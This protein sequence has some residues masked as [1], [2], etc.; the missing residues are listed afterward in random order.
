M[1]TGFFF[2]EYCFWHTTG[3]H[4]LMLPVGG[5]VQGGDGGSHAEAPSTKRRM[6]SLMDVSGLTA[7]LDLQS[8]PAATVDDLLRV[9]TKGYVDKFMATSKAGGGYIGID[10]P[11]G[12]GTFEV[13]LQSAGLGIGAVDAVLSGRH[14]N[15]YALTRPPGHHCQRDEGMGFCFLA[16]SSIVIEWAKQKHGLGKVAVLDWDV[17]HGNGTQNIFYDRPD[18]MTISLHQERCF[19]IDQGDANERGEGAGEGTNLNIPLLP[20]GGHAAYM[21]AFEKLVLPALRRFRPELIIVANGLDAN[22]VDPLARMLLHSDSFRE[23]TR[24][25][26]AAADDLCYGRLVLMHEGGYSDAYVP[27]CGLAVIEEL[28]GHRTE[29]EDPLVPA[30]TAQQPNAAFDDLQ[31]RLIAEMAEGAGLV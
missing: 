26:K 29:V 23:M 16:N 2:D 17:H 25:I 6:K 31:S 7:K 10:A 8:A 12:P 30:I 19:P 4:V 5:W 11:C 15:A 20:G 28:S 9:H 14:D 3:E 27:F 21:E 22:G 13:A 24:L 18:V 1:S